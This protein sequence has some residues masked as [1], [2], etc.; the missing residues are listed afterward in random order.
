MI[1]VFIKGMILSVEAKRARAY[2]P[3]AHTRRLYKIKLYNLKQAAIYPF[4]IVQLRDVK[5][6]RI[7]SFCVC[8]YTFQ[9]YKWLPTH[10]S[11]LCQKLIIMLV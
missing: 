2:P 8:D 3:I 7:N 5:N 11:K 10:T 9:I 4:N 1:K 6:P